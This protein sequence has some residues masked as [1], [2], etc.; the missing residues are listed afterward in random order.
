MKGYKSPDKIEK[1]ICIICKSPCNPEAYAHT[2]C[3]IS[4][5]AEIDKKKQEAKEK[6]I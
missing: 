3:C 4:Y 2:E 6:L 5:S 1:G